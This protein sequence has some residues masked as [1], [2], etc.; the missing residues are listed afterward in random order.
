M[1]DLEFLPEWYPQARR[2]RRLVLLQGW[3]TLVLIFGMGAYLLLV[4][5]NIAVAEDS[6]RILK[7]QLSQTDAQLAEM[8]KLDVMRRQLSQQN[9][10][11]S[12][13]GLYVEA[14]GLV[15]RV[16]AL[17]PRQMAVTGLRLDNEEKLDTSAIQ[18]AKAE[19][20]VDRRLKFAIQG[21]C[22][23]DVDLAN[24]MTQLAA[25]RFFEQVNITYAREKSENGHVMREFEITFTINL[26]GSGS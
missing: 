1:H 24:F 17:M 11:L 22:P 25:E 8:D 6:L 9:Q 16:D 3:L 20:V 2:R 12:R 21:V 23:T 15:H 19:Q 10:I 14:C 4:E 5:R 7:G 13:L 26:N 18:A